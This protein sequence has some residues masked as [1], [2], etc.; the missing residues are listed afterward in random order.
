[1][2]VDVDDLLI[3]EVTFEEQIGVVYGERCGRGGF[4]EA[5]LVVGAEGELVDEDLDERSGT[6]GGACADKDAVHVGGVDHRGDGEL[7]QATEGLPH[8]VEDRGAEQGGDSG[9]VVMVQ[10]HGD[11]C[12]GLLT[13]LYTLRMDGYVR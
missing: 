7:L 10:R 8:G 5:D 12:K 9:P 4:C 11:V 2:S 1:M 13:R 6:G 3:E